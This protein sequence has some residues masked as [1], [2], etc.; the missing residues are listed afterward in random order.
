MKES[1]SAGQT[2]RGDSGAESESTTRGAAVITAPRPTGSDLNSLG[3]LLAL[4]E[5]QPSGIRLAPLGLT[6]S[7]IGSACLTSRA[8]DFAIVE[9][10]WCPLSGSRSWGWSEASYAVDH[11]RAFDEDVAVLCREHEPWRWRRRE[12]ATKVSR[13][14]HCIHLDSSPSSLGV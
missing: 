1:S 2:L 3:H 13:C 12:S 7:M 9:N 11:K 5:G 4:L 10:D 6:Q 14:V 8:L